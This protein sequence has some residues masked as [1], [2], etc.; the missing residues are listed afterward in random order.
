MDI[1]LIDSDQALA[2]RL[3]NQF[4]DV[5]NFEA[6]ASGKQ[7]L[8]TYH[9]KLKEETP[10]SCIVVGTKQDD[11]SSH[12]ILRYIQSVESLKKLEIC[13]KIVLAETELNRSELSTYD[14]L[15]DAKIVKP[16]NS[17]SI[18]RSIE[19]VQKKREYSPPVRLDFA[20]STG[21]YIL[22]Y[23]LRQEKNELFKFC[24]RDKT[25]L[26]LFNSILEDEIQRIVNGS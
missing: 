22:M 7:A 11:F 26:H 10:Y 2:G 17:E 14:D 18:I 19:S 4:K 8:R 16:I 24:L 1:L 6:C 15:A 21:K 12:E 9:K 25:M 20:P 5:Y 13:I 3:K 23:K